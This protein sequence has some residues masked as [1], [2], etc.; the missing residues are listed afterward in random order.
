MRFL[1][2]DEIRTC[3]FWPQIQEIVEKGKAYLKT[4]FPNEDI[5]VKLV[6]E[7]RAIQM[8]VDGD[9]S[10]RFACKDLGDKIELEV[11]NGQ[12]YKPN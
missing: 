2:P 11:S 3:S 7:E 8:W 5:E 10:S 6:D 1:T 12:N 9:R 4:Q